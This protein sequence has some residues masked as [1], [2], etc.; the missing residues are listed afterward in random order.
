MGRLNRPSFQGGVYKSV[1]ATPSIVSEGR[2]DIRNILQR[3]WVLRYGHIHFRLMDINCIGYLGLI[4]F[5]LIFFHKSVIRWPFH[6]L[7]HTAFVIGILELVRLGEKYRYN[8][9]LWT[10]R[11]FYPVSIF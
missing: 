11:T 6:V 9:I 1:T 4:G 7:I 8:K 10:L 2:N 3:Y 5:L